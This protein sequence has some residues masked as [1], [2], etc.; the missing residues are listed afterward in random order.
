M[1]LSSVLSGMKHLILLLLLLGLQSPL[2]AKDWSIEHLATKAVVL[3]DGTI[4]FREIRTYKFDGRYTRADIEIRKRGFDRLYDIQLF[5]DGVPML[6]SDS[7]DPGTFRIRDRRRRVTI[8][9]RYVA[10]DEEKVFELRY[11]VAGAVV[12]GPEHSELFWTYIGNKWDRSTLSWTLD[13]QFASGDS[14]VTIPV[15]A[16]GDTSNLSLLSGVNGQVNVVT[17]RIGRRDGIRVRTVF[18][19][20]WIPN[21]PVTDAGYTLDAAIADE[22]QK[23]QDAAIAAENKSIRAAWFQEFL[24]ILLIGPFFIFGYLYH[25]YGRRFKPS[26]RIPETGHTPPSDLPPAVVSW[27]MTS[28]QVM[29]N[30]LVATLLD[31]AR[32]GKLTLTTTEESQRWG[33]PKMVT[34]IALTPD[35]KDHAGLQDFEI[36]LI[37][38]F[39]THGAEE[40]VRL[41]VLFKAERAETLKW[42]MAWC[43]LV[44]ENGNTRGYYD[45]ESMKGVTISAILCAV[46]LV[47]SIFAAFHIGAIGAAA[48]IIATLAFAFSFGIYRR[49]ELGELTF[50]VWKAY[51]NGLKSGNKSELSGVD[52]GTHV[53]YAVAFGMAGKRLTSMLEN[54]DP[55][56]ETDMWLSTS[57]FAMDPSL[58]ASQVSGMV[59][60]ASA[61]VSAATGASAGSAGGGG[62]GG[63]S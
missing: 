13:L 42:Y 49:T 3:P 36:D 9:W 14:T 33:K 5:E 48:I 20:N 41:D 18:P 10:E 35:S 31:L 8:E 15:W 12:K 52:T 4:E 45:A 44:K 57:G 63:A 47:G 39:T 16:E 21:A 51:R 46:L 32:R 58:F 2:H 29:P 22:E 17:G 27:L 40:P 37:T 43:K 30:A 24:P 11:K 6:E 34:S 25:R 61:G 1:V 53:I 28:Q 7:K 23:A 62:G 54:L 38:F 60:S 19:S 55:N 56:S 50:S 59:A 26:I